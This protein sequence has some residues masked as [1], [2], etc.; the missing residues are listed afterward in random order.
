MLISR[1]HYLWSNLAENYWEQYFYF[2]NLIYNIGL[3]LP[4][5]WPKILSPP[6][7]TVR[8]HLHSW[9]GQRA[10]MC[11]KGSPGGKKPCLSGNVLWWSP[12]VTSSTGY[13][14]FM[15]KNVFR[16]ETSSRKGIGDRMKS[17]TNVATARFIKR[18]SS[19]ILGFQVKSL[20]AVG[21]INSFL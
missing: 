17:K 9:A 18:L 10:S 11:G 15:K 7:W 3:G 20:V 19:P 8:H 12:K 14:M 16:N 13:Y 6:P 5:Q 4:V 21:L 1:R 2:S